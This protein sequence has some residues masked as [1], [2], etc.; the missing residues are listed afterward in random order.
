MA[1]IQRILPA[2]LVVCLF[3]AV[4]LL[5]EEQ[6]KKLFLILKTFRLRERAAVCVSI[7]GMLTLYYAVRPTKALAMIPKTYYISTPAGGSA[8]EE[9]A[10]PSAA[11]AAPRFAE[12][13][14]ATADPLSDEGAAATV[15]IPSTSKKRKSPSSDKAKIRELE[16]RIEKLEE[17]MRRPVVWHDNQVSFMFSFFEDLAEKRH[18]DRQQKR[19][20][21]NSPMEKFNQTI[22]R[23]DDVETLRNRLS[24]PREGDVRPPSRADSPSRELKGYIQELMD[25]QEP[26]AEGGLVPP[27]RVEAPQRQSLQAYAQELLDRQK[28][29]GE[30]DLIPPSRVEASQ[31]SSFQAYAQE[32]LDRQKPPAEG[33]LIPPSRVEAPL[34]EALQAHTQELLDRQN[35]PAKAGLI[36]PSSVEAPLRPSLQTFEQERQNPPAEGGIRPPSSVDV[37]QRG[38]FQAFMQAIVNEQNQ[39]REREFEDLTEMD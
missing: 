11:T 5:P 4:S 29:P 16:T 14:A 12:P 36:P 3:I 38:Y 30:A 24:S 34:W 35:S 25:S 9:T 10:E 28:P 20:F 21:M 27:L 15:A 6:K 37:P 23:M 39:S 22:Q 2:S 13:S 33:D 17:R 8:G 18:Q 19:P 32:L 26:P 7:V 31:R 1:R